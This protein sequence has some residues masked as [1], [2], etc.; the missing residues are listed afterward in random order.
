MG[1]SSNDSLLLKADIRKSATKPFTLVVISLLNPVTTII[2]S[3]TAITPSTIPVVAIRI[4]G[5]VA[6]SLRLPERNILF[7]INFGRDIDIN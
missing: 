6:P 2:E 5:P 1:A 4:T 3:T 7:E